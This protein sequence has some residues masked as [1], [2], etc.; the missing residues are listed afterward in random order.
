M[1]PA[2]LVTI[3]FTKT[4]QELDSMSIEIFSSTK[5]NQLSKLL[6]QI[7]RHGFRTWPKDPENLLN[8]LNASRIDAKTDIFIE[9]SDK[10]LTGY[11]L[12]I[13]ET[14]IGRVVIGIGFCEK[15]SRTSDDL[16]EAAIARA[17]QYKVRR[18]HTAVAGCSDLSLKLLKKKQ[19]KPIIDT[20]EMSVKRAEL[21]LIKD[22]NIPE[23]FTFR[24]MHQEK[25]LE[26][27]SRIQ[28]RTFANHW[29][30]SKNSKEDIVSRLSL[31]DTGNEHVT[32]SVDENNNVVG[33]VWTSI[34][35]QNRRT[36][37][38]IL[39]T[40]I[41]EKH[42]GKKLGRATVIKGLKHL[43]SIGVSEINLEVSS[44]NN[45][46]ISLYQSLGFQ[47]IGKLNWYELDLDYKLSNK[48]KTC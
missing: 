24:S 3:R 31:K 11:S 30:Y 47:Q 2:K 12:V 6:N 18:V 42:R 28:N 15:Y 35:R 45:P 13:P 14:D 27:L 21:P 43:L 36:T 25:D 39:M 26:I 40:G 48:Q 38:R 41:E 19:S 17:K 22:I 34:V 23:G 44:R 16:L 46:A 9:I 8:D 4:F 7:G 1:H 29:G 20:L 33:Y 32:F 37:G 5:I 10:R